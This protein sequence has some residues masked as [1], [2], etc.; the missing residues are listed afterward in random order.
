MDDQEYRITIEKIVADG[1]GYLAIRDISFLLE[2][3]SLKTAHE[4]D[5]YAAT[6]RLIRKIGSSDN[7]AANK[8]RDILSATE[9]ED[10][11]VKDRITRDIFN[12]IR[13]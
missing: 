12:S 2:F 9:P 4:R 7:T 11:K 10:K 8:L 5:S 13:R 3:D 6:I 1:K